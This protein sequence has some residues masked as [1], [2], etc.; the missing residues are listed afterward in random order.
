MSIEI[1]TDA[2]IIFLYSG[3]SRALVFPA[4]SG[5]EL[6]TTQAAKKMGVSVHTIRLWC[7]RGLLPHAREVQESR[8]SVWVIPERDLE[9]FEPPKKTGRPPTKKTAK[10]GG[11]K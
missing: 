2:S 1:F 3:C 9:G 5:T 4:M 6:S 10:R 7:R 11:R 8:G